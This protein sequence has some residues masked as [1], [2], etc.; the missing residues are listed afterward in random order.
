MKICL[1]KKIASTL[2]IISSI[3]FL[4]SGCRKDVLDNLTDDEARVYITKYDSA[5]NFSTYQTFRLADSVSVIRDGQL[6]RHDLTSYDAAL[7]AAISEQMVARG[8]RLE[9]DEGKAPDLGL[10]VSRITTEY[11]GVVSYDDY[12]GGYGSYWDPFYWGYGGYGYS[13]PYAFGTYTFREGALS[14]DMLDLQNP[15]TSSNKL[16]SVWTGL[17]RGTGIFNTSNVNEIVQTLFSQSPYIK[18]S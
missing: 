10:Q 3:A 15:D 16:K 4:V 12:W 9:T 7:L 2:L 13:F 14:I 5:V 1:M 18:R 11:T 6:V 8:Y 17:G